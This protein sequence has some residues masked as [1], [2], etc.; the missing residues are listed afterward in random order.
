MG[1]KTIPHS[2][3]DTIV[4]TP[5]PKCLVIFPRQ[6]ELTEKSLLGHHC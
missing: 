1:S 6:K 3:K 4:T 2:Q 5:S